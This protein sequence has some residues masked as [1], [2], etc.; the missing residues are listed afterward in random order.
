MAEDQELLAVAVSRYADS[1]G[2]ELHVDCPFS[3]VIPDGGGLICGQEC[4]QVVSDLVRPRAPALGDPSLP[5]DAQQ[6]HLASLDITKSP[7]SAWPTAALLF[8]LKR[9]AIA[10]NMSPAGVVKLRNVVDATSAVALLQ[11]RGIN[12]EG[13]LRSAVWPLV[14]HAI[15]STLFIANVRLME[16]NPIG[17]NLDRLIRIRN[18]V[19]D[20][21]RSDAARDQTDG[22]LVFRER[23]HNW[24]C[25]A[26]PTDGFSWA[27]PDELPV[28]SPISPVIDDS[29]YVWL[30]DRYSETY[31]DKWN[32]Q[33][34]RLEFRYLREG[35]RPQQIPHSLLNERELTLTAVSVELA[36]TLTHSSG[37][38]IRARSALVDR[39]LEAIQDG[40]RDLAA[41]M[42]AAVKEMEPAD[43]EWANN[44]GF[45]LI[46][47]DP[48][49]ALR[50]LLEARRL[51]RADL[52][53]SANLALT[54]LRLEEPELA[55][56]E[57]ESSREKG[58]SQRQTAFLWDL[59]SL[60]AEGEGPLII[61]IE[62]VSSYLATI[63]IR[64]ALEMNKPEIE[65]IWVEEKA[66]QDSP[67][68]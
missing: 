5:F 37:T 61:S 57:C 52:V 32:Q 54:Y 2:P 30:L 23:L 38:D 47:D 6:V 36:S 8:S 67:R 20:E 31:L 68:A 21:V 27:L 35:Y 25:Q 45:C 14:T 46:P 48:F 7:T 39:A 16:N 12:S 63:A 11:E 65:A 22:I 3:R 66:K 15:D 58:W 26:E 9:A 49:T 29:E 10:R 17:P 1:C 60:E 18:S 62:S 51:G 40:R 19:L 34:L 43:P 41:T 55:L 53:L 59:A 50:S 33:S 28:V 24:L 42:F 64:A 13:L 44:H 4:R 56:R